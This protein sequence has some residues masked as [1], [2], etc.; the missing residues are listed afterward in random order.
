MISLE[1]AD[2]PFRTQLPVRP[3]HCDAQGMLHAAR[4]YERHGFAA[5]ETT[6]GANEEGAP[7]VHYRWPR[8]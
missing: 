2:A 6:D 1:H 5:L 3:R 8:T 7:D 4:F